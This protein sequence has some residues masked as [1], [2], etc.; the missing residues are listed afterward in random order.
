MCEKDMR[1]IESAGGQ[2]INTVPPAGFLNLVT[3]HQRSPM[4]SVYLD[5]E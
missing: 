4:P 2:N 3:V 5:G 1:C